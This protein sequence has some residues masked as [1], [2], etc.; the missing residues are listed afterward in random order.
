MIRIATYPDPADPNPYFARYYGALAPHGFTVTATAT[1]SD[2]FLRRRGDEFDVLHIHWGHENSWRTR[3]PRALDRA[4][5]VAGLWRFLRLARRMG[6]VVVWTAHD[7]ES[8]DTRYLADRFGNALLGRSA[9]LVICHSEHTRRRLVHRYWG[10]P[11]TALVIPLG[12]YDGLYPAPRAPSDTSARYGLDPARRTLLAVGL[13]RQYKGFDTAI[14]AVRRLGSEY[15]LVVA[16]KVRNGWEAVAADLRA[17]AADLPNVTLDLRHQDDQELADLH[18][19]ADC[20]LLPYRWVTGSGALLTS[21]TLGRAV[22]ATD[23]PYFREALAADP[24]AGVL[25]RANEPAALA[26]AIRAFFATNVTARHTAARAA[27]DRVPWVE[28]V[29]PVAERLHTLCGVK[30]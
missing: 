3:G 14:D 6:K 19:A 13:V 30:A 1:F 15:Q 8:H 7:L 26:A 18:A 17:R 29:K 24:L 10:N 23:L 25:C 11:R 2:D 20:V 21:L 16:G 28:V 5:G 9:D 27:A 12:N 4:R 22:V